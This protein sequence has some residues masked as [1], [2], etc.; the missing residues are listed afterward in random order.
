[1]LYLITSGFEIRNSELDMPKATYLLTGEVFA[2][3]YSVD[4]GL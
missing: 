1:M 2:L 3:T 4:F